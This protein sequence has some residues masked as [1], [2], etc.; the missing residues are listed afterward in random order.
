MTALC[1]CGRVVFDACRAVP[2][3][4]ACVR[5]TLWPWPV[6]LAMSGAQGRRQLMAGARPRGA[7]GAGGGARQRPH[8]LHRAWG[9]GAR[10]QPHTRARARARTQAST[11]VWLGLP[12]AQQRACVGLLCAVG[13]GQCG[14]IGSLLDVQR[15]KD[16]AGLRSFYYLVQDLKCFVFSLIT[17]HFK[18]RG[19]SVAPAWPHGRACVRC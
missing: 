6:V 5:L 8:L 17:L 3:C 10:H 15:S 19:P 9:G 1:A 16:P 18:V 13:G 4:A 14:K 2:V 12:N 11:P 7:P